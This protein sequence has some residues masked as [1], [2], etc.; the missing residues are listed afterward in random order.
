MVNIKLL[1]KKYCV[2]F[3]VFICLLTFFE[4]GNLNA[5][6]HATGVQ[7]MPSITQ[8]QQD[9][10]PR[11]VLFS[12]PERTRVQLSPNGEFL[13]YLAPYKGVLNI[14]VG[15]PSDPTHMHPVTDNTKR[16][17]SSYLWAYTNQHIIYVDDVEGNENWRIY[18]VVVLSGEKLAL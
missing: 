12:D 9:L 8:M 4:S 7:N 16:G 14:W 5:T 6:P 13:S 11:S 18:R 17:I 1:K 2:C 3:K 15:K 10:I